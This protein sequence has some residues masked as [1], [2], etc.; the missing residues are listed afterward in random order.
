MLNYRMTKKSSESHH[1]EKNSEQSKPCRL[2]DRSSDHQS[3]VRGDN[4][5]YN[6]LQGTNPLPKQ[7]DRVS[8]VAFL[9]QVY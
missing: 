6:K 4:T 9:T 2:I 5:F 1:H 7:K 8:L 3:Y